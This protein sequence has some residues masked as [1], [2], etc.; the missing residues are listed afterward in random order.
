MEDRPFA[1]GKE[2][3][4]SQAPQ[5]CQAFKPGRLLG[6]VACAL[7]ALLL[8]PHCFAQVATGRI[9]GTVKD[10]R[11]ALVPGATV[12]ILNEATSVSQSVETGPSG[13]YIFEAVNPGTYTLNV[14]ASGFRQSVSHHVE[15]HIQ[16]NTSI[17]VTLAVGSEQQ[18][19]TVTAGTPL[20]QSEDASVGQTINR[21]LVNDMPLVSRDWSTLAMLSSGVTTSAGGS[22]T[23]NEFV[24]NGINNTQNDFRLNGIDDNVEVYGGGNISFN[25]AILPPPDAIEEFK[26]QTSNFSAEFGHSTGAIENAVIKSGTNAI[27]G[28]L[29]E[30]VRNTVFNANDY[31]ANQNGVAR[32]AYHQNQFGGTVGGPV[33]IPKLYDGRRRTF[34]FFDYQGSRIHTPSASN[35]WV[36]TLGMR[37]SNFTNFQD[38]FAL[39]T[40]TRTDA[41]GR[42][43]P[44][45]TV[46]DP[47]TTRAVAAGGLDP[48]SGLTNPSGGTI[49]V[50]DPFY[51]NGGIGGIRDFTGLT[52]NLNILPASRLD[53]NAIKILD[54]YPIPTPGA[55]GR[56]NYY[57]FPSET[58]DINQFDV[59][60]DE[61]IG[62]KDMLFG[63]FDYSHT[64]IY[65]P[66]TLPG[67]AEGQLFGAGP[68][69]GPRYAIALSYTH[70]FTPTLTNEAH[71]GWS[72]SIEHLAGP[73]GSVM[74]I[75]Q[76][77]GIPGVP[78]VPGNGGLPNIG[79][80]AFT[81]LGNSG[82]M[83]T[84]QTITV[85]E[86][87]DNVTKTYRSHTFK[88]GVQVGNFHAPIIQ[89]GGAK[90]VFDFN[91]QYS[92]IPSNASWLNGAPDMLIVPTAST[93][94]GGIDNVGGLNDYGAS[95]YAEVSD[96]R[97][98]LGAYLQDDWK[99][100]RNLTVNLGLRWDHYTPYQEVNG[101]EANFIQAAGDGPSGTYY[102][103][104]KTC[105]PSSLS[106]GFI[107]ALAADNIS[108]VCTSNDSVGNAQDYNFAPRVG[109]AYK[110]NERLVVRG[111]YGI[112][113]GALD[114]QGFYFNLGNNYPF[115][116]DVEYYSP[117]SYTPLTIPS[118][119]TATL[120]NA[121]TSQNFQDPT[122]V[123]GT[124]LGLRGRQ[125][126]FKTGYNQSLN[127]TI[128]D[129][130][131]NRDSFSAAYV[132]SLGRHLDSGGS[133]NAAS[134]IMPPGT[135]QYDTTV[136]GHIPFPNEQPGSGFQD[137]NATSSYHSLQVAYQ[138][139]LSGGLSVLANY[140][141]SK[142][143]TSERAW[144][145]QGGL[146]GYRAQWLP[147]F[148]EQADYALCATDA[149]NVVHGSGTYHLPFGKNQAYLSN[150]NRLADTFAGGWILNF[151]YSYQ[152]GQP[153]T[154]GCPIQTTADFG[155]FANMVSGKDPYAGPHN[156]TQWLNPAA[157]SNPPVATTIGQTDFAPLG[158]KPDQVRGPGFQ[159]TNLS[160][161]KHF[162]I[163]ETAKVEF[164]A[165]AFNVFNWHAFGNPG[166]L[167]FT[168]A[169][170]FSQ[171]T[172]SRNNARILQLAL[173]LYY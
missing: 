68:E 154:V 112:V 127:L 107:T 6:L 92:D 165:E 114:N 104:K 34:F 142:C 145:G 119:K 33:Y 161:L 60:I 94:S 134:A 2:S 42:L 79:V 151:I 39:N 20:L 48:I 155:C 52:Q 111:G 12:T 95:N 89:P 62:A 18:T 29:W 139:E 22:A 126:N 35:S 157:F 57:Q 103:P 106:S 31:F 67:I 51:A 150:V 162:P 83:P 37:N 110:L 7:L 108:I 76:E 129:Q 132:G 156:A 44:L 49:Y 172:Y 96:Q 135:N 53:P 9:S 136:Q 170:N 63:V 38:W 158:G 32:P 75:P 45:G 72:H 117:T 90:G 82:S 147:G 124:G 46:F 16:Q 148:G 116:F 73:Y 149:K 47:A 128:Q 168:N 160:L 121:L 1:P 41:L 115:A 85:L 11:G 64:N 24:V 100:N 152:S 166:S 81:G 28:D 3:L 86:F 4:R 146:A 27:H 74:G 59:R 105:L 26:L 15:A 120:E 140:T 102:M 109:F 167:D 143:M 84:L 36:P 118:G 23:D 30:Y 54:L 153:F 130:F 141:F 56:N 8:V 87:M 163:S 58:N 169:Q 43:Y 98:Y 77:F 137:S 66:P 25:V 19:V 93:V 101:R 122:L 144:Q 78:Q 97:Y 14:I 65:L 133:Q 10:P 17:D 131:T 55:S 88:T 13:F 91:G 70:I 164:R 159:N 71:A 99:V 113:Y 50:R 21:E 61:N 173:K 123:G 69:K 40:G 171:I 138:H 80:S 5:T 125:W